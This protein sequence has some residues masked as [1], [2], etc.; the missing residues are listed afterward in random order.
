LAVDVNV[1]ALFF[2]E[3]L[4]ALAGLGVERKIIL[5]KEIAVRD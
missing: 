3:N 1:K 2:L 4:S 5:G